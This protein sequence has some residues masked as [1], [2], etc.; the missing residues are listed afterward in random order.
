LTEG[1]RQ[2]YTEGGSSKV[3]KRLLNQIFLTSETNYCCHGST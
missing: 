3:P 1:V 2:L